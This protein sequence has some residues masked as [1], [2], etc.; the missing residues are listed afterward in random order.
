MIPGKTINQP[1][2]SSHPRHRGDRFSHIDQPAM[3]RFRFSAKQLMMPS[4]RS[5]P[6]VLL[7]QPLV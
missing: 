6:N 3:T 4:G 7:G 5:F 2:L 1:R